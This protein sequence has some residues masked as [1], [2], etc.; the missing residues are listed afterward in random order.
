[1]RTAP[2]D[3][4]ISELITS[5]RAEKQP[6]DETLLETALQYLQSDT[7]SSATRLGFHE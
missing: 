3:V 4:I 7:P 5:H 6:V 2:T 1:M